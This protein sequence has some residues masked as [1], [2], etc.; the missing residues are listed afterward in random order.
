MLTLDFLRMYR[1]GR[2][3]TMQEKAMN[4]QHASVFPTHAATY[5]FEIRKQI[6]LYHHGHV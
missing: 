1:P 4:N 3:C 6:V 5:G 2:L